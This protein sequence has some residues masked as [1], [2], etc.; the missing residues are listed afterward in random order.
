M[1][2]YGIKINKEKQTKGETIFR[3]CCEP[4][5]GLKQVTV[6]IRCKK[7]SQSHVF[8]YCR[9]Q[10]QGQSGDH[11]RPSPGSH[12]PTVS[13]L[14]LSPILMLFTKQ[15][16]P[17]HAFMYLLILSRSPG[18]RTI[19]PIL[20]MKRLR[21]SYWELELRCTTGATYS[22]TLCFTSTSITFPPNLF[23]F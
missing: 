12:G 9:C 19:M 11:K 7:T 3:M 15:S 8:S 2:P 5:T 17:P 14:I 16:Y 10:A 1:F 21:H 18:C 4:R 22:Q 13:I 20:Q 23:S 6:Q